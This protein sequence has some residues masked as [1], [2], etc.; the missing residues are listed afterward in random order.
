MASI[1]QNASSDARKQERTNKLKLAIYL[2]SGLAVAIGLASLLFWGNPFGGD[3]AMTRAERMRQRAISREQT[4]RH[5]AD[6]AQNN[7][8]SRM[9]SHN[10]WPNVRTSQ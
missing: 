5:I 1:P 8:Q 3:E 4:K 2:I 10:P 9:E 7:T 6:S